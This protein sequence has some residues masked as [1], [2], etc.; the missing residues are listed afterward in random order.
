MF[1]TCGSIFSEKDKGNRRTEEKVMSEEKWFLAG[2]MIVF[3]I[4]VVALVI[5]RLT[6]KTKQNCEYDER[7]LLVRGK[8]FQYGFF[9]LMIYDMFYGAACMVEMPVWCDN[10]AGIFGG[11]ILALLI[12]GIYCIW[13][14]AYMS[15]NAN[16]KSIYIL[17]FV[18]SIS[19]LFAGIFSVLDGSIIEDGKITF[20]SIN[21]LLGI[22]FAVFMIVFWLKNRRDN[23]EAE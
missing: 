8:G 4:A 3:A 20:H 22:L 15:L 6:S 9:T 23:R 7:Q 16:R 10:M 5:W 11:I 19:N 1:N 13:N 12:F 21:L 18:G 14:D 2:M 17:F